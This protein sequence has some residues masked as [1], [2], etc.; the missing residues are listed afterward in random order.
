M[1]CKRLTRYTVLRRF[2]LT[3][4]TT[5]GDIVHICNPYYRPH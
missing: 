3:A 4:K 2:K 1:N 5:H